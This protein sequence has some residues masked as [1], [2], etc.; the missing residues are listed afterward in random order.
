[1]TISPFLV[2]NVL[3]T[4]GQQVDTARRLA[5]INKFLNPA[6][7]KDSVSISQEARR[8]QLVSRV[9]REIVENLVGSTTDNAVVSEIRK[10][11]N[12]EIGAGLIF[13]YAPD[14]TLRILKKTDGQAR[15]L[16]DQERETVL[17]RLWEVTREKVDQTMI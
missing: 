1:M 11:L 16:K 15:E 6:G 14:G 13:R 4:Y 9:T 7:S 2:K 10:A 8:N 12:Q 17:S 3:R 5:R